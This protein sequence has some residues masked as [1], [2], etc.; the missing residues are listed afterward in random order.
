MNMRKHVI[1]LLVPLGLLLS[2]VTAVSAQGLPGSGWWTSTTIQNIGAGPAAVVLSAYPQGTG[3]PSTSS[4]FTIQ[5]NTSKVLLPG[6]TADP[7]INFNLPTGFDGSMVASANEN[8]VAIV[9]VG[10]NQVGSNGTPGGLASAQY[11]GSST[12]A[13]SISYPTVKNNFGNK[14]TVFSVQAAGAN[15]N[16]SAVIKDNAGGT[17]TKTGSI[18]ANRAV[19]LR[20]DTGFTPPMASTN[21]GSDPNTS[22]CLGAIT[23]SVTGGTGTLV[24]AVVETQTNVSPQTVGQSTTMFAASDASDTVFCTVIKH[25]FSAT[26]N[27]HG[28]VTVQNVGPTQVTVQLKVQTDATLGANPNQTY[29]QNLVIPAGASRTYLG[30]TN[31]LGGMPANN[32]GSGTLTAPAGSKLIAAVNESNFAGPGALK[33]T[34]NQCFSAAV[35]TRKVAFPLVKENFGNSTTSVTVQNVGTANTTVSAVYNCTGRAPVTLSTGTLASGKSKVFIL[36]PNVVDNSLCAVTATAAG[37][38]DKIVGLAQ[39]TS[40]PFGGTLD[41]KNYEGFNLQ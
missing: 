6:N 29:T 3:A 34:T 25:G 4:E 27:R 30:T 41:T 32:F 23:V 14:I 10:N 33:A 39:E 20:P 17:H 7:F 12:G 40:D 37:V 21:C 35:A 31:T 15:L 18:G 5:P 36:D 2:L 22:P 28:G 19:Y 26:Q 8:I 11:R 9:Q 38:N 16:Y 1:R 13:S 24:G